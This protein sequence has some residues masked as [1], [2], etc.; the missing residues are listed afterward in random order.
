MVIF[1]LLYQ[2][3]RNRKMISDLAK[4]MKDLTEYLLK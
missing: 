4:L 2:V 1:Y 3:R